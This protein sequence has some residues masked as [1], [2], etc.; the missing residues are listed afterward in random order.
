MGHAEPQR[1]GEHE[2]GQGQAGKGGYR[3]DGRS[4]DEFLGQGALVEIVSG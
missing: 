3:E 4:K 2:G 1:R